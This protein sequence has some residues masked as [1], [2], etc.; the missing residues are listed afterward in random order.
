MWLRCKASAASHTLS[1]LSLPQHSAQV[2]YGRSGYLLGCLMLNKH[3]GAGSVPVPA[4]QA[5]VNAIFE[6]GELESVVQ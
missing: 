6:S 4:M 1:S 2:L 3:L 5:V